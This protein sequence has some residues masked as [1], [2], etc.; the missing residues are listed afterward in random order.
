MPTSEV[1]YWMWFSM[2][3]GLK[4]ETRTQLLECFGSA[5]AIFF[6]TEAD[7]RER[8]GYVGGDMVLLQDKSLERVRRAIEK[9][10]QF[11]A[12]IMTIQDALYPVRLRNIYNPPYV[13]YIKG[14]IPVLDE[15]AAIAI[16]GTRKATPYGLKMGQRMGYEITKGGGL[17]VTGLAA[18]IDSAAAEGAL[19]AN[20]RCVGVL[21]VAIDEVYPAEN[22]RLYQ[23]VS[24]MGALVSE[25]PPGYRTMPGNFP[26]RNRIMSGIS[27]GTLVIEAPPRSGALITAALA[28]EQGRDLFAV[29]GNADAVNS[30]G[31]NTLIREGAGLVM[32]GADVLA[33]YDKL[34]PDKIKLIKPSEAA[35][36]QE[37]NARNTLEQPVPNARRIEDDK[38]EAAPENEEEKERG[39]EDQTKKEIDKVN[40]R[41]YIDLSEMLESLTEVQ[42]LVVGAIEKSG[43]HVDDIIRNT[44]LP[45]QDVLAELTMLMI[46]GVVREASGKRFFLNVR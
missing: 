2:V 1:K 15:E 29:P 6:A 14:R 7:Y 42:L 12:G 18:G 9:C 21:G 3:S 45:A 41:E 23:D 4:P 28:L 19:R 31:A 10:E 43:T 46:E 40:N 20:G 38:T 32:T 37:G 33:E 25:Y 39:G 11:G 5:E 24:A 30:K 35:I 36:P 22:W 8:L 34:F 13:L 44:E 16:V 26:Q 27:V 17:V